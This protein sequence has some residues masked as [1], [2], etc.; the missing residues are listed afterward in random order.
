[1]H[2]SITSSAREQRDELAAFDHEEFPTC[3]LGEYPTRWD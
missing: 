3:L 2:H 1:M